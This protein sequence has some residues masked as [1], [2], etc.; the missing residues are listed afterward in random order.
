MP[1]KRWR[2]RSRQATLLTRLIGRRASRRG[3]AS[4]AAGAFAPKAAV[5][6]ADSAT[7]SAT[8]KRTCAARAKSQIEN[9]YTLLGRN[10]RRLAAPGL[11][12]THFGHRHPYHPPGRQADPPVRPPPRPGR[13]STRNSYKCHCR[14]CPYRLLL[15]RLHLLLF[16]RPRLQ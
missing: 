9:A 12:K 11:P 3:Y 15:P 6:R 5:S 8:S 4:P 7:R 2:L 1:R 14:H 16:E 10:P 13:P